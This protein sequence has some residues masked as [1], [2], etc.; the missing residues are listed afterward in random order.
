MQIFSWNFPELFFYNGLKILYEITRHNPT[1]VSPRIL[2]QI[3]PLRIFPQILLLELL[4]P[5]SL[6]RISTEIATRISSQALRIFP[7]NSF[8]RTLRDLT[9]TLFQKYLRRFIHEFSTIYLALSRRNSFGNFSGNNFDNSSKSC[10]GHFLTN[11]SRDN[12]WKYFQYCIKN[13]FRASF[14]ISF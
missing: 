9:P 13:L 2:S 14:G 3:R 4:L 11:S 12:L 7:T 10:F 5:N 6:P 1:G 8:E